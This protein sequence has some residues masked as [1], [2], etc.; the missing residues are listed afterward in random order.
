MDSLPADAAALVEPDRVHRRAYT[1]PAVFALEQRRIFGRA[2]LYVAHD[3]QVKQPGDFV[4]ATLAGQPVLVVRH[5]DGT[6]RVLHNRCGHRGAR[7]ATE[8]CGHARLLRCPY[9]GWTFATDGTLRSIPLRDGYAE[10]GFD[11]AASG[12]KPVARSA[13]YRGFI[14]ASLA[15]DG[16]DLP[17]FLGD[18]AASLDNMVERAPAGEIEIAGGVFRT[19]QRNNWKIYLENLHDGLH[20]MIVHQ[21]SVEAARRDAPEPGAP[22]PGAP[23]VG[24]AFRL[25]VVAQNGLGYRE[26]GALTVNCYPRGH[27]DMRSFRKTRPD[28]PWFGEYLAAL[29][30]RLG[31][32]GAEAA[33]AIDR[34]NAMF[35]PATSVHPTFM[36]LRVLV[37]EAVDRTRIDIWSFRMK[38]APEAMNRRTISF[39]NTVHSPSSI[40]KADDNDTYR[41][42]QEGL[43]SD[44]GDWVSAHRRVAGDRDRAGESVGA[45]TPLSEEYIRNQYRAWRG[46]MDGAP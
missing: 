15:A 20:P 19:V 21:S 22:E 24:S 3:S 4:T 12:L 37:P 1:D 39:A 7:V 41:R 18:A 11:A 42:V 10:T 25:G 9:H 38:G 31:R 28:A 13:V 30:A 27:S 29:E 33:L 8:A 23:G 35:Y 36:Q 26:F 45:S 2:W 16:P 14:F 32:D 44:G 34:H 46:Y 40:I 43:E 5:D 6:I 17:D